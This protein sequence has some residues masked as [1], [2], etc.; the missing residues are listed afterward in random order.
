MSARLSQPMPW[1]PE[2]WAKASEMRQQGRSIK[3][4]AADLCRSYQS[5][6]A[7]F[8]DMAKK[9]Q[10]ILCPDRYANVRA[11]R[12]LQIEQKRSARKMEECLS[13]RRSFVKEHGGNWICRQCK[14]TDKWRGI[15]Q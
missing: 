3:D 4:I 1:T 10:R 9:N 8:V 11:A 2:E 7:K 13:C 5:V 14:G 15:V 12:R 6:H